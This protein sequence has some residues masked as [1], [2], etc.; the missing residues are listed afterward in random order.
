VVIVVLGVLSAATVFAVRGITDRGQTNSC[1][2]DRRT[3]EQAQD[4]HYA[5]NGGY[6]AEE[7][8]VTA[9]VLT[10]T[11]SMHDVALTLDSYTIVPIG[12]CANGAPAPAPPGPPVATTWAGLPALRLGTGPSTVLLASVGAGRVGAEEIW[13]G[14]VVGAVPATLNLVFVDTSTL[15]NSPTTNQLSSLLDPATVLVLWVSTTATAV[16]GNGDPF[17]PAD[18]FMLVTAFAGGVNLCVINDVGDIGQCSGLPPDLN[19]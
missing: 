16:D 18:M 2:T 15:G 5:L 3:L 4:T 14:A 9:G 7:D 13:N 6:V 12:I 19:V 10:K 1:A 11:S 17:A 8:L